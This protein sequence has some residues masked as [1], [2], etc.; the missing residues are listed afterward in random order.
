MNVDWKSLPQSIQKDPDAKILHLLEV[1]I[2]DF[3]GMIQTTDKEEL[4]QYTRCILKGISD[5][6]FSEEIRKSIMGPAISPQK[7]K[8]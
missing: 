7:L 4:L 3:I 6:F 1:Y 2:D 8:A 5:L